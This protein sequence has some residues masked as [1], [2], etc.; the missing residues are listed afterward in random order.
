MAVKKQRPEALAQFAETARTEKRKERPGLV[1]DN[2]TAPIPTNSKAK[3]EA[4]TKVLQEGATG[5]DHGSEEAI[6][7]L[8]DRII[9]SRP[10]GLEDE[11]RQLQDAQSIEGE[12]DTPTDKP[13]KDELDA[14]KK[15]TP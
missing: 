15:L 4:A 7:R 8:P 11:L 9:E 3:D 10:S 13:S 1:A 12:E 6:D 14:A 5:E 2:D